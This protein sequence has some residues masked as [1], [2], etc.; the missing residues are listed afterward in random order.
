LLPLDGCAEEERRTRRKPAF[1]LPFALTEKAL[2][3]SLHAAV[4]QPRK[5]TWGKTQ[6]GFF[7]QKSR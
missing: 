7:Y 2:L 4:P 5:K 6:R 3:L 1:F